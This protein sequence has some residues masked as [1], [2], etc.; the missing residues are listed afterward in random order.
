[1]A[2]LLV[3]GC[4]LGFAVLLRQSGE[5]V[6]AV[7]ITKQVAPGQH[8]PADALTEVQIAKDSG[9]KYVPW[10]QRGLLATKYSA[11]VE[12]PAGTLL[13]GPMIT[14]AAGLTGDQSV[15]GLALKS[16]QFPPGLKA[17]DRVKVL[18]VGRDAAAKG[19]A[20]PAPGAQAGTGAV[21]LVGSATVR[22]VFKPAA[23]DS[24]SALSLSVLVP[25]SSSGSVVQAASSGDV[26]LALLGS[27]Q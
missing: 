27:A 12:I 3:L 10:E 24:S 14:D 23:G 21:E 18:W 9:I 6:S 20:S 16:G 13:I 11:A 7:Q 22:E 17:G 25:A 15:V 8:I 19:S 4:A 5:R 26:A 1:M 2:L